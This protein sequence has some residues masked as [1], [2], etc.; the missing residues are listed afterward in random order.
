MANKKISQL[1]QITSA[2]AITD[3]LP[4]FDSSLNQTNKITI[5]KLPMSASATARSYPY[6]I[7]FQSG[8]RQTRE[9]T[10]QTLNFNSN[11]NLQSIY[12]GGNITS[13]LSSAFLDC[14]SLTSVTIPNSVTSIG[15]SAF[16]GCSSLTSITIP[17][18]VTSIGSSAFL[19][20]TSLV[21]IV[22][23]AQS[24]PSVGTNSF[25]NVA[26]TAITVPKGA[27]QSYKDE[28]NGTTYGGLQIVE[29]S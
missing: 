23:L 18:N 15:N 21:T 1:T 22:S 11:L 2:N 19:D 24:A 7:D 17:G 20:C 27:T 25:N 26:A 12:I 16:S 6:T 29:A 14:T 10:N 8:S 9:L 4:I 28:G 13:I 5:A 3:I